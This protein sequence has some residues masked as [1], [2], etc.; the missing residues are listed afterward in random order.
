MNLYVET[1]QVG[2]TRAVHMITGANPDAG[3]Y[4]D[5]TTDLDYWFNYA[6]HKCTDWNQLLSYV[7]PHLDTKT[8]SG[9]NTDEKDWATKAFIKED[10]VTRVNDET[11]KRTFLISEYPA[12]TNDAEARVEMATRWGINHTKDVASC[13]A[14]HHSVKQHCVISEFLSPDERETFLDDTYLLCVKFSEEGLKGSTYGATDGIIDWI[15]STS[16][17]SASGLASKSYTMYNGDSEANFIAALLDV[18][19]NGVY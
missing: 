9:L 3:N 18:I 14:R 16:G 12:I 8:W 5:R 1:V 19:E 10:A 17:Y 6:Q 15:N 4:T 2:E 13:K 7:Q 11:A